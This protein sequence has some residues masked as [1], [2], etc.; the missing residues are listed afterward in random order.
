METILDHPQH[1]T[2]EHAKITAIITDNGKIPYGVGIVPNP[3][4]PYQKEWQRRHEHKA[5]LATIHEKIQ[6]LFEPRFITRQRLASLS[7]R[8]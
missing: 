3:Y 5:I 6:S 4:V 8:L 2:V 1:K 7:P